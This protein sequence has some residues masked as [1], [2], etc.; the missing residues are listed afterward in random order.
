M[1]AAGNDSSEEEEEV[2]DRSRS[3]GGR[4]RPAR[5]N[6]AVM[7]EHARHNMG[8]EDELEYEGRKSSAV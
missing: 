5:R 8:R 3:S 2:K 1:Y 4:N 6:H 7:K